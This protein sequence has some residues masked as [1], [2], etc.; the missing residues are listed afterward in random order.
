MQLKL[1][2]SMWAVTAMYAVTVS[3]VMQAPGREGRRE[4]ERR[5]TGKGVEECG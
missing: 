1:V 5:G 3:I 4:G 2:P